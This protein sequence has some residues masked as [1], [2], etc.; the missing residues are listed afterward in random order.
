MGPLF[1]PVV[2]FPLA[3]PT[4]CRPSRPLQAPGPHPACGSSC[5]LM[6]P[7]GVSLTVWCRLSS[8][9]D[10]EPAPSPP[11]SPELS[12][13]K[14]PSLQFISWGPRQGPAS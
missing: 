10:Q 13:F 11:S 14:T 7:F 4:P 5:E 8:P 12:G 3:V 2:L 1:S 6:V 9:Q